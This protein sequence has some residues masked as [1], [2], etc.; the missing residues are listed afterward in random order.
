MVK[1]PEVV[2]GLP[3][4]VIPVPAVAATEV[5][6]PT[7]TAPVCPLTEVTKLLWSIFCQTVPLNNN[8]SP[9]CQSVIPSRLVEPAVA[10]M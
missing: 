9:I 8:Q 1:V 4:T 7:D 2:I 10:V 3:V 5:T 6:V